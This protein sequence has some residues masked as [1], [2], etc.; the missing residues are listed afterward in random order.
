MDVSYMKA[1]GGIQN[2]LRRGEIRLA[3]E[4]K[5]PDLT[6]FP[7]EMYI[8]KETG[9]PW[10]VGP[11]LFD[12]IAADLDVEPKYV[13]IPWPEHIR[14]LEAGDVDVILA[15]NT[16]QRGLQVGFVDGR[17][18]ANRV[19]CLTPTSGGLSF[20]EITK[21]DVRIACWRGSS[22]VD[23]A[24]SRFPEAIVEEYESPEKAVIEGDADI[25]INDA[26]T[27]RF[28]EL[29]PE[30]AV[31]EDSVL[32]REFVHFAVRLGDDD[33]RLWLN[34]WY[35]YHEAQGTIGRWCTDWW[36]SFMAI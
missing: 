1:N 25:Y 15:T 13:D 21:A 6:G 12:I 7:P 31:I 30:L 28:L 8:D 3:V 16:P 10:G 9:K 17:L 34:N 5:D 22:V 35:R 27:H 32:S 14:A 11:I 36:E 4:F 26:I 20:Q 2:I 29:N 19:V 18:M 24:R 23:V 33:L